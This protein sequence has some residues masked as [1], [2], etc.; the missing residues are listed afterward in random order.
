MRLLFAFLKVGERHQDIRP[1]EQALAL[2]TCNP[3]GACMILSGSLP[4]NAMRHA[5]IAA[6]TA[7]L[8]VAITL[9]LS[10]YGAHG[11]QGWIA[12]YGGYVGGLVNW[13]L[14]PSRVSS[15][16]CKRLP[17]SIDCK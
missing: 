7:C 15:W 5:L 11:M 2:G 12:A 4:L 13:R 10:T 14:N 1:T 8:A 9:L 3:H 16:W 6:V 17:E